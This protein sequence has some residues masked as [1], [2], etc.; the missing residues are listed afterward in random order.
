MAA[1]YLRRL[2]V[3]TAGIDLMWVEDDLSRNPVVLELSPYYQP[4][5]PKPER[6]AQWSY[7]QYKARPLIRD[8]YIFQQYLAFRDIAAEILDQGLY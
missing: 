1:D 5:P 7:K 2:G 3:R 8:G 6:Y 4:N